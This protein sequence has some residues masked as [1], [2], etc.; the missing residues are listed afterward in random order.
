MDFFRKQAKG[1]IIISS[2]D[3]ESRMTS[4]AVN[5]MVF[6]EYKSVDSVIKEL[7]RVSEGSLNAYMDRWMTE[8]SMQYFIFG[9]V[10]KE[11]TQSWLN[12]L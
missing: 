1:Q 6:G 12:G 7:D 4:L 11:A 8:E 9:D 3:I 10:E 2:E 5:E